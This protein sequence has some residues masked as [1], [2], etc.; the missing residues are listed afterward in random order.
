MR[1]VTP[2]PSMSQIQPGAMISDWQR[3]QKTKC[4]LCLRPGWYCHT[5]RLDPSPHSLC[6][7][8]HHDTNAP[9]SL[10]HKSRKPVVAENGV[11]HAEVTNVRDV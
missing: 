4:E 3:E 7:T 5:G 8:N 2:A 6:Q 1:T 11:G 9:H 10:S